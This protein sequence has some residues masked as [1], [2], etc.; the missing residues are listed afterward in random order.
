MWGLFIKYFQDEVFI[1]W[2]ESSFVGSFP[3]PHMSMKK[4]LFV[5]NG[6]SVITLA[7]QILGK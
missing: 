5:G 4:V 3:H 7:N 6:Y 1:S 2:L